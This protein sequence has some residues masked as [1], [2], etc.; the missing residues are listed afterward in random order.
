MLHAIRIF[1]SVALLAVVQLL[2]SDQATAQDNVWRVGKVSGEAWITGSGVQQASLGGAAELKPGDTIRTGRNGR[3]LLV[4]GAETMLVSANS[5]VVVP[6]SSGSGRSTLIQQAGSVL[7]DVEK[8]NVQHFEVET[9]FLAAVVKGTQFRVTVTAAGA[10]VDVTRG[11]VEVADFRSGQY[12]LVQPG[13]A[14]SV[15]GNGAAGLNL[16]GA[17]R[18]NAIQQGTPRAPSVRPVAVPRG[19]LSQPAGTSQ[20]VRRVGGE[21]G[22]GRA[23]SASGGGV[24]IGSALGEVKVNVHAVTKGLSR[25]AG[26]DGAAASGRG[27]ATVWATGELSPGG[28]AG[29]GQ[30]ADN[31]ETGKSKADGAAT[32]ANAQA[33]GKGASGTGNGGGG[34]IKL[35]SGN[36]GNN[37]NGNGGGNAGGNGNGGNGNAGG[38]GNGNA[39]GNGNQ[40]GG[41]NVV[42]VGLGLGNGLGLGLGLGNGNSG[43][44]GNGGNNGNGNGN[45]RN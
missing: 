30:R 37:G 31:S 33:N 15:S 14:A 36:A 4:R 24:R 16:S 41:S 8:R 2:S 45:G 42:N 27:K 6:T 11:Q 20:Q 28:G 32:A 12:A 21:E 23:V 25:G 1:C 10:R 34:N 18:F 26:S 3:V 43:G 35:I 44:N 38:N 39:G 17:G 40:G 9:P 29:N 7:L 22:A 5:Q 13:Q 19:G